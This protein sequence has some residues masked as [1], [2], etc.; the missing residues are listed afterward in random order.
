MGWR[1]D[2]I[3]FDADV[4]WLREVAGA[5]GGAV[6]LEAPTFIG[7]VDAEPVDI[8]NGLAASRQRRA[9]RRRRRNA[10]RA[11]AVALAIAPATMLPLAGPKL[12]VGSAGALR[13]DPPSLVRDPRLVGSGTAERPVERTTPAAAGGTGSSRK[14]AGPAQSPTIHWRRATSHGLPYAG[15]LSAGTQLPLEG[16]DW[17][18]WNPVA[19]RVPNEP[20]RLYGHELTIRTVLSVTA[21]Y[22]EANPAA[23]RVVV[24]DISFRAGGR[25]ELHRS[26]QNG[27][28]VD[29]YYPR[30]D[31]AVRAPRTSRRIDRELAQ[32]LVDRF[33][34]A[35]AEKVFV[36]YATGL[37]GPAGVVVPYPNHEDHMHVRFPRE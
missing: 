6:A 22:R 16:P 21:A 26:H 4:G 34:A 33:V 35:G 11:G 2:E 1:R 29:I 25:M 32:D 28:D 3:W 12:G 30:L 36:G 13:E 20:Q 19:D 31:G 7:L 5:H 8:P 27:L 23:P 9:E 10:R 24:G 37:R 18:T 14:R 17:V 15:S